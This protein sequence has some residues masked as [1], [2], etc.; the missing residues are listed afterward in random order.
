MRVLRGR[1]VNELFYEGMHLLDEH[2]VP[3]K[4]RAGGVRVAPWPVMSIYEHPTERVLFDA[5]RDANPFFHLM[6][7]LWMLSGRNDAG[8]LNRYIT[9]FGSRFAESATGSAPDGTIH[10]A[11]GNRWRSA[12]GFDQLDEIVKKLR[13]NPTDRQCVLQM[14]D[15]RLDSQSGMDKHGSDEYNGENDLLGDWRTRPCNTHAYFRVRTDM[16]ATKW[17]PSENP[18]PKM[19]LDMTICCRSNDAVWGAHGANAVHFSMM[20][21]YVAGRIGVGVGVMYQL[22]SNYHAYTD[23]LNKIGDPVHLNGDD[24]YENGEVYCI[25]I[26][27]DWESWDEDLRRFMVWHDSAG[28]AALPPVYVNDWFRT[29]AEHVA[30][31]RWQWTHG[32]K[33]NAKETVEQIAALDWRQACKEWFERRVK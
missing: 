1:N 22:S 7:G 13:S 23:T 15:A 33:P 27:S 24:P 21:E 31:A 26:G 17:P 30:R 25:P 11:Y 8:F 14:W 20:Q 9:D 5:Q 10:D 3:E 4:S 16:D 28:L 32:M 29:V 19:V 18:R 6:E 12:M 2:G